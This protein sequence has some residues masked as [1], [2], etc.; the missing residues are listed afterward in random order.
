[1]PEHLEQLVRALRA[2]VAAFRRAYS[3]TEP[4]ATSA[5]VT[6]LP[7]GFPQFELAPTFGQWWRFHGSQ[8]GPWFFAS[9]DAPGRDPA[10]IGRFDLPGPYGACYL[11]EYT[12]G[13]LSEVLREPVDPPAAQR[14]ADAKRMSAMPLDAYYGQRIADFTSRATRY[15]GVPRNFDQ[16]SREEARPFAQRAHAGGFA[17]IL[18]RLHQDP[19]RRL[20]LALFGTAGPL[21][22]EPANQPPPVEVVTGL[23][24]ELRDLFDGEYRGDPVPR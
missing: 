24:H 22:P 14:A 7:T 13:T 20:G 10:S 18:Y 6:P 12:A 9:S 16:L 19:E 21:V 5:G 15:D 2:A 3:R 8:H 11:G 4:W 1:M 17:G 23:R